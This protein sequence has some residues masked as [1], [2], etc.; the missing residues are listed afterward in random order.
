MKKLALYIF[1]SL[2][3]LPAFSESGISSDGSG[4]CIECSLPSAFEKPKAFANFDDIAAWASN[5]HFALNYDL[6]SD[7]DCENFVTEDGYGKLATNFF[8]EIEPVTYPHMIEGPSDLPLYCPNYKNLH[9][10]ER[11]LI[12]FSIFNT[13]SFLESNCGKNPNGKGPHGKLI[14]ILQLHKGN[15]SK[16]VGKERKYTEGCQNGDGTSENGSLRCSALMIEKQIERSNLLFSDDSYWAVFRPNTYDTVTKRVPVTKKGKV[17]KK[18]N[19]E[20]M[21]K[22]VIEKVHSTKYKT[23]QT[24]LQQF[25]LCKVK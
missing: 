21:T 25:E 13:A 7:Q 22:L 15:E 9:P 2:F 17:L 20:P 8:D 12:W 14:G 16:Y 24:A 23:I 18:K 19:G 10:D 6:G 11:E 3:S 4:Y 1:F 5:Y